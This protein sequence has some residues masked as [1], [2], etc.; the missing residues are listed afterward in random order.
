MDG[1]EFF[2]QKHLLSAGA[3]LDGF[4]HN[5]SI[6]LCLTTY[7]I[8]FSVY[9][10]YDTYMESPLFYNLFLGINIWKGLSFDYKSCPDVY[11]FIF[12][13]TI[14][15]ALRFISCLCAICLFVCLRLRLNYDQINGNEERVQWSMS[16]GCYSSVKN[17]EEKKEIFHSPLSFHSRNKLLISIH[18]T[19][20]QCAENSH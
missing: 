12:K 7:S 16:S 8:I 13:R 15:R 19:P 3:A 5:D 11:T 9:P 17:L 18:A 1:Y 14:F 4:L 6:A 10:L 20:L 2:M